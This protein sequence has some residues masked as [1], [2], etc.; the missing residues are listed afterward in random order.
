M[1]E[2]DNDKLENFFR[3]AAERPELA[4]NEDDWKKLEAR[5]DAEERG[6]TFYQRSG[7]RIIAAV[8]IGALLFFSGALWMH[9]QY[10]GGLQQSIHPENKEAGQS[11]KESPADLEK[12]EGQTPS[13]DNST[14][15]SGDTGQVLENETTGD[16][17]RRSAGEQTNP[18]TLQESVAAGQVQSPSSIGSVAAVPEVGSEREQA[19]ESESRALN[20]LMHE[21]DKQQKVNTL[22]HDKIFQ[23]LIQQ[24][25]GAIATRIKQ[26]AVVDL[27]GA[28]EEDQR[29]AQPAVEDEKASD[30]KKGMDTPRLSLLLSFAPDFSSTSWS[31][32]TTPGKAFGAMVHYHIQNVW[33]LSVGAIK[34]NKRYTGK[35]EDYQPPKGY[36]KY[37]TNGVVPSSIEGACDVVEFPVMIQYTIAS[38]DK[39]RWLAGAGTSSYL[40]L[41]ESYRYTFEEP[42]PGAKEGWA[43]KNSSRFLFNMINLTVGFE[44]SVLPGLMIGVEPYVKIPVEE[45]GWTNLKLFSS[46]AS[47]T[48]R[49]KV[50][51]KRR[52]SI[53]SRSPGPD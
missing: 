52:P 18:I 32:Y 25:S 30:R 34:N 13:D 45:I 35:G 8:V 38:D 24:P 33:S 4:F 16:A 43:S 36:W 29:T 20:F 53:Q 10:A 42:N 50:L 3:K 37:Y 51:G 47:V 11:L 19:F 22:T 21:E 28:E 9:F 2:H 6:L 41:N 49:Y 1:P 5:L 12:S 7:V 15:E 26:K 27:P 46:G 48:L 31:R 17:G 14:T 40:M 44:R 23:D 39:N